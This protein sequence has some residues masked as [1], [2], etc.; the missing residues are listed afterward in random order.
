MTYVKRRKLDFFGS[1]NVQ[2]QSYYC[3]K[4]LLLLS[5]VLNISYARYKHNIPN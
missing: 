3:T 4:V 2:F 5:Y 1:F